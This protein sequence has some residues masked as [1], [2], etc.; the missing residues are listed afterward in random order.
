MQ[1]EAVGKLAEAG[2][3]YKAI[4]EEDETNVV[5]V[6]RDQSYDHHNRK[7]VKWFKVDTH[8]IAQELDFLI[9]L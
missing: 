4:L 3:I 5:S 9:H 7:V 8:L 6:T 2:H 1:L